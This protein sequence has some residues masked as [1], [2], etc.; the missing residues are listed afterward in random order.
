MKKILNL[1][2]WAVLLVILLVAASLVLTRYNT[3]IKVRL[4][5]VQSGSME[6]TIKVGSVVVVLPQDSYQKE[7]IITVRSERNPKETVTHRIA[8][9]KTDED[10]G[11]TSFILKGDANEDS[12]M[13]P[14]LL[15][16]AIGKV[17]LILPFVGYPVAFA[18]TQLGFVLLIVIPATLI[19]YSEAQSIKREVLG[20]FSPSKK[21]KSKK[22]EKAEEDQEDDQ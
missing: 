4:F 14:V 22:K 3:P 17:I 5:A 21:S 16:R 9:V 8:K 19:I 11:N 7:D 20:F 12:D 18:Q 15:K 6:P 2:Y 13:E 10:T 1:I